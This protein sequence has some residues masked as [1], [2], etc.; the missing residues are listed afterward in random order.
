MK[1]E[2]IKIENLIKTYASITVLNSL[3][4]TVHP[5]EFI[6]LLGKNGAGK[7]TLIEILSFL[8]RKDFGDISIFGFNIDTNKLDAKK[9]VGVV[10]QDFRPSSIKAIDSMYYYA[11]YYGY[12][13]R[14]VSNLI[15]EYSEL[16][17]LY[18]QLNAPI[19]RLS[20]GIQKIVQLIRVL[21]I[22]PKVL[23]L[24]E[25]TVG[26]DAR[27]R[28]IIWSKLKELNSI[29]LTILITSHH[30]EEI[31]HLCSRKLLL[32]GGKIEELE[33]QGDYDKQA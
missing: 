26:I 2:A 15:K 16:F 22:S 30:V 23:I 28:E 14:E 21:I 11:G 5:G 27:Y 1:L 25:P 17:G 7:T 31:N 13:K 6:G 12:R 32:A 10:N 29:G 4:L 18:K 3:S 33:A 20:T 24:D 9:L 19:N 8:R